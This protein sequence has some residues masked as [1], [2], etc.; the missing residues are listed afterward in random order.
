MPL[1]QEGDSSE[2]GIESMQT[3]SGRKGSS[4]QELQIGT[5]NLFAEVVGL[6]NSGI[7]PLRDLS[8]V[9][10]G[11]LL[12]AFQRKVSHKGYQLA[13]CKSPKVKA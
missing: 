8:H 5:K 1:S 3:K 11:D 13:E 9:K 6:P 12:E 10:N 4:D 7:N 2:I